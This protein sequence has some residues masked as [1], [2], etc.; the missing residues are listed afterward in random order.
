MYRIFNVTRDENKHRT[1]I[2]DF[3]FFFPSQTLNVKWNKKMPTAAAA[4]RYVRHFCVFSS[5]DRLLKIKKNFFSFH[6]Q[7]QI[8]FFSFLLEKK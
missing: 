4:A 8:L 6:I 5:Y 2:F 1:W 7:R 3:F